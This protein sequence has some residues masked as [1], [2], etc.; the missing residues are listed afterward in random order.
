MRTE[1]PLCAF[2]GDRFVLRGFSA[3]A[4]HGATVAGGSITRVAAPRLR[5]TNEAAALRALRHAAAG[6][7]ER[8]VLELGEQGAR[9]MTAAELAPLVGRLARDIEDT[10]SSSPEVVRRGDTYLEKTAWE[11]LA[12]KVDAG[13]E[14]KALPDSPLLFEL[15]NEM[16]GLAT[17]NLADVAGALK[18]E[19]ADVRHGLAVLVERGTLTR[20]TGDYHV[21]TQAL[22]D[23]RR[24]LV[25][26]L[27][28][29]GTIE[30][31]AWKA[32]VGASRK[33]SIPLAEYFDAVKLTLRVGN[34]RKLRQMTR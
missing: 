29:H 22:D 14:P 15:A 11:R 28:A 7:D 12:E 9:G 2:P 17:P 1:G 26:H 6:P 32:L 8:L 10:L 16:R 4:H 23:L 31:P 34:T 19:L 3:G 24:R 30:P 27:E 20:I 21:E 33:Y 25:L 13:E 18:C 5:V